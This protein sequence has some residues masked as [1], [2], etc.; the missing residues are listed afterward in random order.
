MIQQLSFDEVEMV[1]GAGTL[2]SV[3]TDTLAGAVAG[4][5]VGFLIGGPAGAIGGALSGGMHAGIISYAAH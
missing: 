1:D 3:A 4:A 5:A 2:D